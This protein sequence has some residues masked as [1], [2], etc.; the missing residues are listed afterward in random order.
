M[1]IMKITATHLEITDNRY[2][3]WKEVDNLR[4]VNNRLCFILSGGEVVELEDLRPTMVDAVFRAYE[5]F[6]KH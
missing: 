5:N 1:T 4:L 2:I 3:E 6:L